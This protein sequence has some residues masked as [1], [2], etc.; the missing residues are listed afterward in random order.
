MTNAFGLL[1]YNQMEMMP[2]MDMLY[3]VTLVTEHNTFDLCRFDWLFVCNC[4]VL[5]TTL[6]HGVLAVTSRIKEFWWKTGS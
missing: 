3:W 6:R 4:S 1:H 5:G 2:L